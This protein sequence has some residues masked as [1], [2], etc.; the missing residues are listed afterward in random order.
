MCNVLELPG[1][2]VHLW[3]LQCLGEWGAEKIAGLRFAMR[4][5]TQADTTQQD[6][7]YCK[8]FCEFPYEQLTQFR[9]QNKK[10]H[11]QMQASNVQER[12]L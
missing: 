9:F 12:T 4:I 1:L 8:N 6:E 7:N 11:P 2:S 3:A 5:A 10:S